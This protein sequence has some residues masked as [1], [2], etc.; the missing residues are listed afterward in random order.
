MLSKASRWKTVAQALKL[1]SQRDLMGLVHD[2]YKLD[3]RN[4]AFLETRFIRDERTISHYQDIIKKAIC[5]D[6]PWKNKLSL[7]TGRTAISDYQKAIGNSDGT[8]ELMLFYV[9][10]G[11]RHLC[12]YGEMN[13]SVENSLLSMFKKALALIEKHPELFDDFSM[14]IDQILHDS[15]RLD[16]GFDDEIF[17]LYKAYRKKTNNS[18]SPT[19]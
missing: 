8:L 5:P 10:S 15:K 3:T 13:E 1:C 9:E 6:E 4:R 19:G 16:W 14:D 12:E 11:I 7:S 17:S 2:L 18:Q